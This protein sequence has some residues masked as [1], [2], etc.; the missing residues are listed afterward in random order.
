MQLDILDRDVT[1]VCPFE[2][3]STEVRKL[4]FSKTWKKK[5]REGRK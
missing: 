1:G 5:E 3:K 2:V 4:T